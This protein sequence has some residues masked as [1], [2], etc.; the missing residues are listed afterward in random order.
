MTSSGPRI[1]RDETRSSRLGSPTLGL[2]PPNAVA[3]DLGCT[4]P[5]GNV[6][7]QRTRG[8]I[9][10]ALGV[11]QDATHASVPRGPRTD[12]DEEVRGFAVPRTHIDAA[13]AQVP[14]ERVVVSCP[15][16]PRS[17]A[18]AVR[19]PTTEVPNVDPHVDS[20]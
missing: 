1:E 18:D 11:R 3:P 5:I 9:G 6:V 13:S 20:R 17:N 2:L 10:D 16:G 7:R 12:S 19:R 15:E 14:T 8:D 4:V